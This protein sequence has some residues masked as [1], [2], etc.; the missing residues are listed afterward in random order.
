MRI[1]KFR[2]KVLD[3]PNEWVIGHLRDDETIFQTVRHEKS[4]CCDYGI[5]NIDRVTVGQ[6]TGLEDKNGSEIYENDL[7][8]FDERIGI[9]LFRDCQFVIMVEDELYPLA[10]LCSRELEI[11]GNIYD[12]PELLD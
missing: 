2:G 9:V 7:C 12:N 11:V 10:E 3:E 8:L 5:F 6:Y 1:I 4:K